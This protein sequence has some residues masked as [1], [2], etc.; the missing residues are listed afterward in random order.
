MELS[1][2]S[3]T[4]NPER[5]IQELSGNIITFDNFHYK[6]NEIPDE[7]KLVFDA[8][9]EDTENRLI[10][11]IKSSDKADKD[12][13]KTILKC[14]SEE[15]YNNAGPEGQKL[16]YKL[17][18]QSSHTLVSGDGMNF[19]EQDM[20]NNPIVVVI[21]MGTDIVFTLKDK[22]SNRLINIPLPRR[23]M[24][25]LHDEKRK[26]QRGIAKRAFDVVGDKKI[27]RQNR[28]SVLFESRK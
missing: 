14:F 22:T 28:Y 3:P 23:S 1:L 27:E 11:L 25:L 20:K 5:A 8:I 12:T 13:L 16:K 26:F 6:V 24:F 21:N 18:T 17:N 7:F 2:A 9:D 19:V 10:Q 15:F 4:L